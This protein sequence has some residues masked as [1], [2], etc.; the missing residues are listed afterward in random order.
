[1]PHSTLCLYTVVGVD[2][3]LNG[4]NAFRVDHSS[5]DKIML[6]DVLR[7]FPLRGY[8]EPL[9]FQ[10]R[11]PAAGWVDASPGQALPVAGPDRSLVARVRSLDGEGLVSACKAPTDASTDGTRTRPDADVG[12]RADVGE[13]GGRKSSSPSLAGAATGW[14]SF[15]SAT[16]R[17]LG[18]K[19]RKREKRTKKKKRAQDHRAQD[20]RAHAPTASDPPQYRRQLVQFYSLHNPEKLGSVDDIL[21]RYEGREDELFR[22]LQEKYSKGDAPGVGGAPSAPL[23]SSFWNVLSGA[24]TLASSV[25]S[26][27]SSVISTVASSETV[28]VGSHTVA[29]ERQLAE[30]GFSTVFL[31]RDDAQKKKYA[32]KRMVVQ[33]REQTEEAKW[34]IR[35]HRELDHPNILKIIDASIGPSPRNR[36][37][38]EVS[39]LMPLA[40]HG[41]VFDAIEA[42]GGGGGGPWPFPEREAL[43]VFERVCDATKA[44]HKH[45]WA[46]RDIK[47]HNVLLFEGDRPGLAG[48]VPVLMDLGST[49]EA[50]V[51]VRSRRDAIQLQDVAASKCSPPYRAPELFEVPQECDIDGRTDVFSL[52]GTLYAMAFGRSPFEHPTQGFMKLALLNGDVVFPTDDDGQ[53]RG[54]LGDPYSK[55]FCDLV[56]GMLRPNP[57]KRYKL[58]KVLRLVRGMVGAE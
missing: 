3:E 49:A 28:V 30:G 5:P 14:A 46:H 54:P 23:A 50:K 35:V 10:F 58:S 39:I 53:A 20:H 48:A 29:V 18:E 2:D 4:R 13:G 17:S 6:D 31:V 43:R 8:A 55:P 25:I 1:M 37:A 11:T 24:K 47:P 56:R 22:T 38:Q 44:M 15:A 40:R 21:A 52:G 7:R 42:G 41:S 19:M 32:L 36:S 33:S 26:T 57:G 9:Q 16:A 27:A 45:G 34:E 12:E 51:K